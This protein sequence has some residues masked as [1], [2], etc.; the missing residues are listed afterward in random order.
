MAD[1]V[2]KIRAE[3]AEALRQVQAFAKG[4]EQSFNAVKAGNPALQAA[5][6][7]VGQYAQAKGQATAALQQFTAQLSAIPGPLGNV[8]GQVQG[9]TVFLAGPTGL[10]VGAIA[11]GA[12]RGGVRNRPG[13][14]FG[15][16]ERMSTPTAP[17]TTA[18]EQGGVRTLYGL[19]ELSVTHPTPTNWWLA[20]VDLDADQLYSSSLA[21]QGR[22]YRGKG[23]FPAL[24]HQGPSAPLPRRAALRGGS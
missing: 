4:V 16:T 21:Y 22:S 18:S 17:F 1:V 24:P 6:V 3:S 19:Y 5:T 20:G 10:A 15:V 9:L 13:P 23:S 14:T 8:A 12:A 2:L 11:A 7:R